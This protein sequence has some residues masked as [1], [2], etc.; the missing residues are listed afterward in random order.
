MERRVEA[1]GVWRRYAL[2]GAL[3]VSTAVNVI[4][5]L[6]RAEPARPPV[7][8]GVAPNGPDAWLQ[9]APDAAVPQ[10]D[11]RVSQVAKDLPLPVSLVALIAE[12]QV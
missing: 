9:A 10:E 12:P 7:S 1:E 5:G 4:L 8:S 3:C 2:W 6:S 11:P